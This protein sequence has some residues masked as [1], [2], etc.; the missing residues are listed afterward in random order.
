MSKSNTLQYIIFRF[1]FHMNRTF[2]SLITHNF[3]NEFVHQNDF[4]IKISVKGTGK[5]ND[6][7]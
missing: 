7:S 1:P 4:K 6:T 2:M 5:E 3:L